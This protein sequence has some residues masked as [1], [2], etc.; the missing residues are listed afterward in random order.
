MKGKAQEWVPLC[1]SYLSAKL[2]AAQ[3]DSI[4]PEPDSAPTDLA[5]AG[6][7]G[8]S[9]EAEPDVVAG[10]SEEAVEGAKVKIGARCVSCRIAQACLRFDSL[11]REA[12]GLSV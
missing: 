6:Q 9:S 4:D 1:L 7:P 11:W 3:A 10:A 8:A 2:P 5:E 12:E